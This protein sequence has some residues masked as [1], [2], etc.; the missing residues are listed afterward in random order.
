MY[1]Y[2]LLGILI[3]SLLT[4]STH[5]FAGISLDNTR[6]IFTGTNEQRGQS[7]GVTSSSSSSEPYLVKAQI[8]EDI[9]GNNLETP[10]TVTPSIFRLE[11]GSTNQLRI[12][13]IENRKLD[14][15]KESIFYLRVIAMPAGK[16][17]NS[18]KESE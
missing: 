15:D 3:A 5:A 1:V 14:Q 10:F 11:P 12:L 17:N 4:I 7:I 8:L 9:S 18:Q 13:K 2:R 16:S 6:I